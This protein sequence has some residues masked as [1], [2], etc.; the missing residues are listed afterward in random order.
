[1]I[2]EPLCPCET[3]A[4]SSFRL[5]TMGAL[6]SGGM[7]RGDADTA[8]HAMY[9]DERPDVGGTMHEHTMYEHTL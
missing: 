9:P 1:M 5:Q 8:T 6:L 4:C 2:L 7:V 3:S